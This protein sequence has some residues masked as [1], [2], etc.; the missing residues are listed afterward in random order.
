MD[1]SHKTSTKSRGGGVLIAVNKSINSK[2]IKHKNYDVEQI[3]VLLSGKSC[4][5]II[6]SVYI[7]PNSDL[8]IYKNHCE[9]VEYV[10]TKYPA[11]KIIICGDYNLS[12]CKFN[13][14]NYSPISDCER[15]ILDMC[16]YLNLSQLNNVPNVNNRILDLIFSNEDDVNVYESP[17]F[18]VPIDKHH[19]SLIISIPYTVDDNPKISISCYNFKNADYN[20]INEA[21]SNIDW[22]IL[23]EGDIDQNTDFFY[24]QLYN[25]ISNNIP[26]TQHK[27]SKY[28]VWFTKELICLINCKKESHKIYKENRSVP[29]Y[30]KFKNTRKA[31]KNLSKICYKNYIMEVE[32]T[33]N[34]DVKHFWKH[35]KSMKKNEVG[36]PGTMNHKQRSSSNIKEIVDMFA[37][38]FKDV[39]EPG[40]SDEQIPEFNSDINLQLSNIKINLTD[41]TNYIKTLEPK[42]SSGP[43]QIPPIL[44]KNCADS[45]SI[46]LYMLFNKSLSTGNF[47]KLWKKSYLTPIFKSGDKSSIDN[48]RPICIQSSIPKLFEKLI[49][50]KINPSVKSIIT[51]CQHGFVSG[52]STL[53]NL[54]LYEN[55]ITKALAN[56]QQVDSIYT[57]FSKAFDKV[58]LKILVNKLAEYGITGNLLSW[59][60]NYLSNRELTVCIKGQLSYTFKATSG[61]PQGSHLGPILFNIFIN[62]VTNVFTRVFILM[63]ADDMKIYRI[64]DNINDCL[65]LQENLISFSDWC[66]LNKLTLN[67]KKCQVMRFYRKNNPLNFTY[68]LNNQALVP[69]PEIKDLGIIFDTKLSFIPHINNITTKA[70]QML[71]FILRTSKDFTNLKTLKI[72][73]SSIV[74]SHLE[75]NST[76]WNPFYNIRE[77]SIERIQHKFLRNINYRLGIPIENISYM[78]LLK[79]MDLATLKERRICTDLIFLYKIVNNMFDSPELLRLINFHVPSRT[80]R[81]NLPYHSNNSGTNSDINSVMNRL[82]STGNKYYRNTNGTECLSTYKNIIIKSVCLSK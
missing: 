67:V 28:P 16:S 47:P 71:G 32:N 51:T 69:V 31:C 24:S 77:K 42:L 7:P 27:E 10:I 36:I 80:V 37:D 15:D 9:D 22:T 14:P 76:I 48:Y 17:E 72:L 29:N 40:I 8:S 65:F 78:S 53:T 1:R 34:H 18:I 4:K 39:F 62:D 74:R 19:P 5:T 44:I 63:F 21:L 50:L 70:M 66:I 41:I 82:H 12:N 46:P 3:F 52:R 49:L 58:C 11:H 59:F 30:I 60:M 43:D 45:L 61:V 57:D 26:L 2:L 79:I 25:V 33:I 38:F 75:F 13:D 23:N 20:K 35:V 55:Y 6:G 68:S 54:S 81:Q 64:I 56:R 73:Y